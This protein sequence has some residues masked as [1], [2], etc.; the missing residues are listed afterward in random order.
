MIKLHDLMQEGVYDPGILKAVFL[1]GGPGSGKTTVTNQ[2]FGVA[3]NSFSYGGLKPVNSDKFFEFMLKAKNI[4][5]DLASLPPEEFEKV[6]VGPQSIRAQS[7]ELSAVNFLNYLQGRLGVLI[8]GTGDDPT[9]IIKEA[10]ELKA[11]F[12]Y[13]VYMVFVNTPLET[14]LQRNDARERKLPH[15]IVTASWNNA[16]KAL[17]AYKNYFGENFVEVVN[18]QQVQKGMPVPIDPAITKS[19]A[20]FMNKPVLNPIGKEWMRQAIAAKKINEAVDS[21][22]KIYCDMDGVLCDFIKQWKKFY[23]EDAKAAKKL[24]KEKFDSMLDN[25]PF[26]FWATMEWM[27][28]SK[29]MW[30]II[31]KYGVTILSSP[32]ESKASTDGKKA[33][34]QKNIPG[35]PVIFEKSYNKQKH[36][37]PDAILIDDYKRNVD[38]WKAKGGIEIQYLDANQVIRDLAEWDIK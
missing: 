34:I 35:T 27:P 1:A 23:G 24:D 33:W 2:L 38:Q 36:A 7:K 37:A 17:S 6:T 26:E 8:D 32:A 31:S 25:A 10:E 15:S 22:Y 3:F 14:A 12:G 29:R 4:P 13:D 5:T 11:K 19:V 20:R 9:R 28:G 18:D 16:Q 30:D 21:P